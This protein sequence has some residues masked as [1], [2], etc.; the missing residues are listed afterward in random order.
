MINR[1][2]YLA[3]LNRAGLYLEQAEKETDPEAM[4]DMLRLSVVWVKDARDQVLRETETQ[5]SQKS[6]GI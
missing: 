6:Q 5:K 2:N 1:T 3:K 4:L